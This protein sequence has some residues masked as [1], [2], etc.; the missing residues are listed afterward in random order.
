MSDKENNQASVKEEEI[1]LGKLFSLIGNAFSKLFKA[2][3]VL[4]KEVFHYL[5]LLL[6]FIREHIV[7]L[8]VAIVLGMSIGF[9]LDYTTPNNYSY[10][11]IIEP[12]YESIHQIFEKVEYYNVLIEQEDSIGLSKE[13]EISYDNANSLRE[14]VLTPYET[15]KDQILAFDAFIKKTDTLTQEYFS[16][17]D[18]VG[19]GPSQFDSRRYAYRIYS[20]SPHQDLF[21]DKILAEIEKNPTIQKKKEIKLMTLKLDSLAVRINLAEIDSLR[22]LYKT[23]TL[24]D[25]NKEATPASGTY[26]DFSKESKSNNNDLELFKI[27]KALNERLI[28]IE[29]QKETSVEVVNVITT[30]N[31][32]GN[33]RK[34]TFIESGK[35]KFGVFFGGA[36]LTYLLLIRLNTY[37]VR[38]REQNNN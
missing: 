5:I 31:P 11:M 3:G 22:S 16:F 33:N 7:K 9:V 38:Y 28:E 34:P 13:F 37:L 4:L 21:A 20:S 24:L 2:I 1:D 25:A 17:N 35:F 23:V 27:S 19:E 8:G 32:V 26:L 30:F 29:K 15:K 12:N 6:L 18:F 10:D 14:F 36:M